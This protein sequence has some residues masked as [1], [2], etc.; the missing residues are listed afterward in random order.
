MGAWGSQFRHSKS[1]HFHLITITPCLLPM[2]S[3]APVFRVKNEFPNDSHQVNWQEAEGF[4][5]GDNLRLSQSRQQQ[6]CPKESET[7]EWQMS[8]HS[9]PSGRAIRIYY[10]T[11]K[12]NL[13]W[14][15]LHNGP[16][17]MWNVGRTLEEMRNRGG[18]MS[19]IRLE[20]PI[21]REQD[22]SDNEL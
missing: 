17:R 5:V 2:L 6:N 20:S 13:I 10:A 11:F 22:C 12:S 9:L 16:I 19:E 21:W 7:K 15:R 3:L 8:L 14:K 4:W 1:E 18:I